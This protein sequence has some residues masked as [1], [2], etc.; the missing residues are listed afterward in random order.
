M[1]N[2]KFKGVYLLLLKKKK[3]KKRQIFQFFLYGCRE[4][5]TRWPRLERVEGYWSGDSSFIR[6]RAFKKS[7]HAAA[8]GMRF[9]ASTLSYVGDRRAIR[10]EPRS[11][12]GTP[13]RGVDTSVSAAIPEADGFSSS[14]VPPFLLRTATP[15]DEHARGRARPSSDMS[16]TSGIYR[17]VRT[18]LIETTSGE[19]ALSPVIYRANPSRSLVS[20]RPWIE[21]ESLINLLAVDTRPLARRE[22]F[23]S[24]ATN[25]RDVDVN[26]DT[27]LVTFINILRDSM[28]RRFTVLPFL[29]S[30]FAFSPYVALLKRRRLIFKSEILLAI[31]R[32]TFAR[33]TRTAF[34][35]KSMIIVVRIILWGHCP[36]LRDGQ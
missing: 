28:S 12:N 20:P 19:T 6:K 27:C 9:V 24:Y 8:N 17:P 31:V 15:R 13:R 1:R 23:T 33:E 7:R 5:D 3:R 4:G 34:I 2:K 21:A 16:R 32:T 11:V 36:S 18:L 30:L 35:E 26:P 14:N 10:E 29:F 22:D 25:S